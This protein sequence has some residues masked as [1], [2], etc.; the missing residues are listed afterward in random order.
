MIDL[1]LTKYTR[2]QACLHLSSFLSY[3]LDL[4]GC[5]PNGV[6]C[7]SIGPEFY[8]YQSQAKY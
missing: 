6:T 3:V 2:K 7:A 1:G 5:E 4:Y 8:Q